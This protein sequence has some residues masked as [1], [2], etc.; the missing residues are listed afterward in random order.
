MYME[1][2][3]DERRLSLEE[4]MVLECMAM[5][6]FALASG[7]KVP[8]MV[9]RTIIAFGDG[10]MEQRLNFEISNLSKK[11]LNI[12]HI[13]ENR[14]ISS[15]TNAHQ[16]LSR[17]VEP[18]KPRSI[19]LLQTEAATNNPLLFLGQVPLVRRMMVTAI[20]FLI[21]FVAVCLSPDVNSENVRKGILDSSGIPLLLTVLLYISAAGLGACFS[22][23]FKAN[24]FIVKGTFDP[25][26]ET[27]YWIRFILGIIA[28]LILALLIPINI[29]DKTTSDVLFTKPLLSMLGGFSSNL[30]YNILNRLVE[31]IGSLVKGNAEA[32]IET[33]E[34]ALKVSLHEDHNERRFKLASDIMKLQQQIGSKDSPESIKT[35]LSALLEDL[36]PTSFKD[37]EEEKES[38][39]QAK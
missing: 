36:V 21:M 33:R 26:Y 2:E 10:K 22:S 13:R 14:T 17:I 15:L 31:T 4:Q 19:L 16:I 11:D 39:V 29:T 24:K 5:A 18:A 35:K 27:S 1:K 12:K 25:K 7:K 34:Q 32:Q 23:L 38:T 6:K 8:A 30:V 3:K 28:G 20:F 9:I 37:T